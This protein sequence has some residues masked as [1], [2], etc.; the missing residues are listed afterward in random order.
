VC[1]EVPTERNSDGLKDLLKAN[2]ALTSA[3][4]QNTDL[5]K[6]IHRCVTLLSAVGERLT[7]GGPCTRRTLAAAALLRSGVCALGVTQ[8][9]RAKA[10]DSNP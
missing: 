1:H 9:K 2:T 4:T 3:L 10:E 6:E 8:K 5:F 7:A